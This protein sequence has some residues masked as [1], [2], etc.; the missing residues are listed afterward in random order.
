MKE[1]TVECIGLIGNQATGFHMITSPQLDP[2]SNQS[3]SLAQEVFMTYRKAS[4]SLQLTCL[5]SIAM[6]LGVT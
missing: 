2:A 3:T 6:I 1:T 4:N 5:G